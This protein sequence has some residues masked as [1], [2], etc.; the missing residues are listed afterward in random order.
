[1]SEELFE[2]LLAPHLQ[3]VRSFVRARLRTRDDADDVVQQTLL[4]AFVS[5]DQLRCA[6]KFKNWLWSIASNEIRAFLRTMRPSI[7]LEERANGDFVDPSPS[8]LAAC[9]RM[10]EDVRLRAGMANLT[11]RDRMAIR[12]VDLNGLSYSQAAGAMAVSTAAFKSAHFRARQRLGRALRTLSEPVK[13]PG[14][15]VR[16]PRRRLEK[17]EIRRAA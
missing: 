9:E 6:P 7:S 1:M 13:G 3:W 8:A 2:S 4:R 10:E 16:L 17:E 14:V 15:V 11:S 12:L 5:R